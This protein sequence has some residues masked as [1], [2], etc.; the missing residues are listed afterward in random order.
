MPVR[1]CQGGN[2]GIDSECDGGRLASRARHLGCGRAR[3]LLRHCDRATGEGGGQEL[4]AAGAEPLV[5][6]WIQLEIVS[7][8]PGTSSFFKLGY[9]LGE[10]SFAS[11]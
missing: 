5:L 3:K 11:W 1:A 6:A 8:K 4:L 7:R 2:A 9:S 10:P